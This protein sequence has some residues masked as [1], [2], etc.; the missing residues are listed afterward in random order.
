MELAL[1]KNPGVLSS[2]LLHLILWVVPSLPN[3]PV[4]IKG[5]WKASWTVSRFNDELWAVHSWTRL[6]LSAMTGVAYLH[7]SDL[8]VEGFHRTINNNIHWRDYMDRHFH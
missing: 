2:E 1:N 7:L 3:A 8:H 5:E 6:D 4:F